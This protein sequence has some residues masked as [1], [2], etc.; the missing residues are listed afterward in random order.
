MGEMNNDDLNNNNDGLG[1]HGAGD[2]NDDGDL[3]QIE[4]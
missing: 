4:K 3:S 2:N 1:A